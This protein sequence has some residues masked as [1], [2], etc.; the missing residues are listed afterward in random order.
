[1]IILK[2]CEF[3]FQTIQDLLKKA[4]QGKAIDEN[5]IPPKIAVNEPT[6]QRM[7]KAAYK[8]IMMKIYIFIYR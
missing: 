1:L 7:G 3:Q 2:Y 4:Q 8:D 6:K 5:D